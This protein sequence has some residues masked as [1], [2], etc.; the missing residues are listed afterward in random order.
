MISFDA[1]CT[2]GLIISLA[3]EFN[4]AG[5]INY[6][7]GK[8]SLS[9]PSKV[10]PYLSLWKKSWKHSKSNHNSKPHKLWRY[11]WPKLL[12]I[13]FPP[14]REFFAFLFLLPL[15]NWM[16]EVMCMPVTTN[17][18]VDKSLRKSFRSDEW[19]TYQHTSLCPRSLGLRDQSLLIVA[20]RLRFESMKTGTRSLY[21][22]WLCSKNYDP[23]SN[24]SGIV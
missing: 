5:A 10:I 12:H 13:S 15:G 1:N 20:R 4:H 18:E 11:T 2:F 23:I 7:F 21:E 16:T 22:K 8:D 17:G 3:S 14:S 6:I 24:H 19:N 9:L